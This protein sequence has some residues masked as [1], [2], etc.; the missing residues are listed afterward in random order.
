VN[1][2]GRGCIAETIGLAHRAPILGV[3]AMPPGRP[4]TS[5]AG[6]H[7][8]AS[9]AAR[10]PASGSTDDR[11]RAAA[12]RRSRNPFKETRAG[13][14]RGEHHPPVD[15]A[16]LATPGHRERAILARAGVPRDLV[17][18][19]RGADGLLVAV[20]RQAD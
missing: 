16:F 8:S 17:P 20:V 9:G 4:R 1:G 18:G 10:A 11:R 19:A 7:T 6:A 12:P 13:G 3:A 2:A 5:S 14:A 15:N